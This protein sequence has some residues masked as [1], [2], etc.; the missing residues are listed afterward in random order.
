MNRNEPSFG[1][2]LGHRWPEVDMIAGWMQVLLRVSRMAGFGPTLDRTFPL[3]E[4][5]TAHAY[6][7]ERKNTGKVVLTTE[8]ERDLVKAEET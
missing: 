1:V 2:N 7:E 8:E 6:M 4:V 3:V 5:G